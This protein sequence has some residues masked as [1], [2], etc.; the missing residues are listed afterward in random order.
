MRVWVFGLF[1]KWCVE[2]TFGGALNK[3][4]EINAEFRSMIST[5]PILAFFIWFLLTLLFMAAGVLLLGIA[6]KS[7]ETGV[8]LALCIPVASICY[9]VYNI[10]Y[11]AWQ[12]F[13]R[14]RQQLFENL[15]QL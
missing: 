8:A 1:V 15:K 10:L 12:S 3:I 5:E 14:D 11:V 9:F 7:F 2:K 4:K 6:F 13:K